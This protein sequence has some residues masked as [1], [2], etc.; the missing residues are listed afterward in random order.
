LVGICCNVCYELLR[1]ERKE[2]GKAGICLGW[3]R[4]TSFG[5]VVVG[6]SIRNLEILLDRQDEKV[7]T[8]YNWRIVVHLGKE[9]FERGIFAG[10]KFWLWSWRNGINFLLLIV[11]REEVCRWIWGVCIGH[12]CCSESGE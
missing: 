1:G 6:Y 5:E 7:M 8:S 3:R 2:T 12:D 4:Q 9:L 10:R 11:D